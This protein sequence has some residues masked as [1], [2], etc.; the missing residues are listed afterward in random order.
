MTARSAAAQGA[1]V[2][3]VRPAGA[4]HETAVVLA[5][6]ALILAV[7]GTVVSL[8]ATTEVSQGVAAHQVDARRDLLPA[9]QGLYADLRVALDEIEAEGTVLTVAALAELGLPPFVRDPSSAQ[10]GGHTW[11]LQA[12]GA[13]RAYVGLSAD[14]EVAGSLLLRV[15]PPEAAGQDDGHGH[16]GSGAADDAHGE[17]DVWFHRTAATAPAALDDAGLS[18]AGWRQVA[19]RF[20]AGVTRQR[21]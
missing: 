17:P 20:D 3:I 19:A 7:A 9:E 6:C 5:V 4:G 11:T 16:G 18:R 12:D 15:V 2:Q 10:R 1:L 13:A 8:R 14:T 21:R